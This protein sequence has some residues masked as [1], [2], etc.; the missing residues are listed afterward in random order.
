LATRRRLR[1]SLSSRWTRGSSRAPKLCGA[2]KRLR[3]LDDGGGDL[4]HVDALPG[5]GGDG[6]E[7]GAG[8]E[9]DDHH[10]VEIVDEERGKVREAALRAHL[11]AVVALELPVGV[12]RGHLA[13]ADHG[14]DAAV[15]VLAHEVDADPGAGRP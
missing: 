8:A 7:R 4:G 14:G 2:K 1:P 9:A 11:L 13:A 15:H 5:V 12:H 3:G 6:P 10:P